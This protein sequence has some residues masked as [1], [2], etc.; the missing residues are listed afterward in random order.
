MALLNKYKM[1]A[2][3][4]IDEFRAMNIMRENDVKGT[5]SIIKTPKNYTDYYATSKRKIYCTKEGNKY[6]F[7]I[8]IDLKGEL[9]TDTL[10]KDLE[11]DPKKK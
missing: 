6:K 2:K 9:I 5:I 3:I 10:Y 11:V 1:V 8:N 4:N 7:T